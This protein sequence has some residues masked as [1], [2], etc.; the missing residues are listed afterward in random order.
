MPKA[1]YTEGIG[2]Q[3]EF[4]LEMVLLVA[5]G[6]IAVFIIS[7]VTRPGRFERIWWAY[8]FYLGLFVIGLYRFGDLIVRAVTTHETAS[9][10]EWAIVIV[11]VGLS[12]PGLIKRN[13]GSRTNQTLFTDEY[14][15]T[16]DRSTNDAFA[17][18]IT[19]QITLLAAAV[20]GVASSGSL[21]VLLFALIVAQVLAYSLSAWVRIRRMD[22]KQENKLETEAHPDGHTRRVG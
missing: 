21:P 2:L 4:T 1:A 16:L 14:L 8:Y 3:N 22:K 13:K 18:G 6:I 7:L 5:G 10:L 12:L 19:L 11:F 9:I 20:I 15:G 17:L